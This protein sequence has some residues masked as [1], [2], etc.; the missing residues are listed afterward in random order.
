MSIWR[1]G[2]EIDGDKLWYVY[3]VIDY[4]LPVQKDNIEKALGHFKSR[5][6]AQKFADGLNKKEKRQAKRQL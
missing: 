2:Q 3:R 4:R 6:I 5:E 1:V